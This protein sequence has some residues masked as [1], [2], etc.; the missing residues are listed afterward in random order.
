MEHLIASY[1]FQNNHCPLPGIG[2]LTL[3]ERPATI[4]HGAKLIH[5]PQ[6]A[7]SLVHGEF[8]Q[9]DFLNYVCAV[10]KID[11]SEANKKLQRYCSYLQ[12]L[13]SFAEAKIPNAG[14]FYVNAEGNLV[15]K[16]SPLPQQFLDNIHAEKVIH[17]DASHTLI[18]GDKESSTSLMTEYYN[19]EE[20]APRKK[21]WIAA[22]I[23]ALVGITVILL[24]AFNE[25]NAGF[26][27]N[28]TKPVV[29]E[30]TKT[31]TTPK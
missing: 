28:A 24:Y 4:S 9:D 10:E 15:F 21:W 26:F 25:K 19:V 17:P 30:A 14:K 7:I 20:P 23:L 13:D 27:G 18:V 16:H 22:L 12:S 1:L 29:P 31:Y 3:T 11:E 8:S 5:P 2:K 6:P